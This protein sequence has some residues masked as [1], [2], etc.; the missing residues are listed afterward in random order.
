MLPG[1][2]DVQEPQPL[3][4]IMTG[5]LLAVVAHLWSACCADQLAHA[6]TTS[7]QPFHLLTQL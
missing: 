4:S 2:P 1:R 5:R 7:Q 6:E 3:H